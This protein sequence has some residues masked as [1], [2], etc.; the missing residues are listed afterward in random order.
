MKTYRDAITGFSFQYP[1]DWQVQVND[2]NV[3]VFDP[4]LGF[5]ALQISVYRP[6]DKRVAEIETAFKEYLSVRHDDFIFE[7]HAQYYYSSVSGHD[8][9]LWEYWLFSLEDSAILATY[10]CDI[11][12]AG[13]ERNKVQKIVKSLHI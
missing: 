11:R 10:N 12:D 1:D 3:A 2:D 4:L 7:D 9:T 5:G 6:L 13:K 8:G